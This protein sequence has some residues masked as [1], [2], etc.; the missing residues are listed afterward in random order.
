MRLEEK[1]Q[2]EMMTTKNKQ[3]GHELIKIQTI[4]IFR[5]KLTIMPAITFSLFSLIELE[6]CNIFANDRREP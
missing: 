3:W 6:V 5:R 4:I 2:W 1:G